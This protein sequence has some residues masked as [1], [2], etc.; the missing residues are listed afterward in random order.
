MITTAP[1]A[2]TWLAGTVGSMQHPSARQYA[3]VFRALGDLCAEIPCE[4]PGPSVVAYA[5]MQIGQ[6]NAPEGS[7]LSGQREMWR[8]LGEKLMARLSE[9]PVACSAHDYRWCSKRSGYVFCRLCGE[10]RNPTSVMF[11]PIAAGFVPD[12]ATRCKWCEGDEDEMVALPTFATG[13]V[14]PPGPNGKP[15]LVFVS[16]S[17]PVTLP[18][19]N[20][21]ESIWLWQMLAVVAQG[22]LAQMPEV[23]GDQA[24]GKFF[25]M[26]GSLQIPLS[27]ADL[28]QIQA[29]GQMYTVLLEGLRREL[30]V[31]IEGLCP[32][33]SAALHAAIA[34]QRAKAEAERTAQQTTEPERPRLQIV[35]D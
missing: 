29:Q 16:G 12:V 14:V 2:F 24:A 21:A 20:L 10:H 26:Q 19:N 34:E 30:R 32:E 25:C 9:T 17:D 7:Q 13:G 27:Q 18:R 11:N 6:S 35:K 28:M 5:L 1:Q 4:L 3:A 22:K 15:R 8:G 33:R 31:L 23:F